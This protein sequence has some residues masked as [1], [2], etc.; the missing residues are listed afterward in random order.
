MRDLECGIWK[1]ERD[2][3]VGGRLEVDDRP[4]NNGPTGDFSHDR[5]LLPSISTDAYTVYRNDF[6]IGRQNL[7]G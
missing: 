3:N 1:R 4:G 5:P 2:A 6:Q 7:L